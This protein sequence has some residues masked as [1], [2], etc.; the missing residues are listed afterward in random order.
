MQKTTLYNKNKK[1]LDVDLEAGIAVSLGE[2]YDKDRLPLCLQ[3]TLSVAEFNKWLEKRKIPLNREGLKEAKRIF[4]SSVYLQYRHMFALTD[5]YW[6]KLSQKDSWQKFNFFTN[7]YASAIGQSLFTPWDINKEDLRQEGPDLTTNGVLRKVWVQDPETMDSYLIKAGSRRFFQQP[8]SE[9]LASMTLG[10][11][12]I[13]P[14][15][16]YDLCVYGMRICSKCKNFVTEDT[17]F[18]PAQSIYN[19][20]KREQGDTPFEHLIRMCR[21]YGIKQPQ[22][23]IDKMLLADCIIGNH[24]R[25]MG[26]FGALQNAETGEVLG[27]AP[28]F[29]FGS[30]FS[31]YRPPSTEKKNALFAEELPRIFGKYEYMQSLSSLTDHADLFRLIHTYPDLSVEQKDR[32]KKGIEERTARFGKLKIY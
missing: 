7:T 5:Q 29:D 13:I 25:H 9:V 6:F 2:L 30:A 1:V 19:R 21:E 8:L 23:F 31:E 20:K 15:V 22:N 24:D 16:K 32:I 18:V 3:N 12:Q 28:L 27:F 17:E 4:S 10:K 26:N 14:F 11:I